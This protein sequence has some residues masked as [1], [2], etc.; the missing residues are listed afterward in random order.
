MTQYPTRQQQIVRV[1]D[2][3]GE[4]K[5]KRKAVLEQVRKQRAETYK[6]K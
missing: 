2:K 6:K 5:K 1:D 3:M 4:A